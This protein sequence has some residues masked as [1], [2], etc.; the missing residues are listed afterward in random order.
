MFCV[1]KSKCEAISRDMMDSRWVCLHRLNRHRR[2]FWLNNNTAL[3]LTVWASWRS[4]LHSSNDWFI[5]ISV[6]REAPLILYNAFCVCV[7]KLQQILRLQFFSLLCCRGG[8]AD[9]WNLMEPPVLHVVFQ[10]HSHKPRAVIFSP[11]GSIK[12]II[13]LSRQLAVTDAQA[14]PPFLWGAGRPSA[15][16]RH[17]LLSASMKKPVNSSPGSNIVTEL[18]SFK[19]WYS[20]RLMGKTLWGWF[21]SSSHYPGRLF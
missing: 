16:E 11:R 13:T 9:L 18:S 14:E 20:E 2:L 21:W 17:K 8:F 12:P 1:I 10:S 7:R 4:S 19:L 15:W 3:G 6:R 5:N